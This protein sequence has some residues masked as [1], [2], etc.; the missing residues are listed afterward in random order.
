[1]CQVPAYRNEKIYIPSYSAILFIYFFISLW[2]RCANDGERKA[3]E[4]LSKIQR[5]FACILSFIYQ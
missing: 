1:M 2:A 3:E 4:Q 5:D